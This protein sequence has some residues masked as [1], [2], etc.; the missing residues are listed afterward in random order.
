MVPKGPL[1]TAYRDKTSTTET[2][3]QKLYIHQTDCFF[4]ILNHQ[5]VA[6]ILN[7]ST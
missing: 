5:L 6:K 1:K 2:E 4:L 3:E 7:L